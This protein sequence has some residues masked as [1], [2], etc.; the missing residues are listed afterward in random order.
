[1]E[2]N[3]K[4]FS[5]VVLGIII[6]VV[7]IIISIVIFAISSSKNATNKNSSSSSTYTSSSDSEEKDKIDIKDV[8]TIVYEEKEYDLSKTLR[9]SGITVD[10]VDGIEA[11]SITQFEELRNNADDSDVIYY[12]TSEVMYVNSEKIANS[13]TLKPGATLRCNFKIGK[14]T[15]GSGQIINS[16][17]SDK[18]ILDCNI[19]NWVNYQINDDISLNGLGL[20]NSTTDEVIKKFKKYAVL[21]N[22]GSNVALN[23]KDGSVVIFDIDEE[24]IFGEKY[25]GKIKQIFITF[26]Y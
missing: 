9:E 8:S 4:G 19:K 15:F 17:S 14:D 16:S 12:E 22:D 10:N 6:L 20:G 21:D 2:K 1:M 18:N 26:N 25:I 5:P 13:L 3:K 11:D 7:I 23:C 24:G